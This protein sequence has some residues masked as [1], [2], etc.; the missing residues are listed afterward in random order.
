VSFLQVFG[1][2]LVITGLIDVIAFT[3]YNDYLYI[4]PDYYNNFNTSLFD[5]AVV[6]EYAVVL[7]ILG[8]LLIVNSIF[9]YFGAAKES[10]QITNTVCIEHFPISSTKNNRLMFVCVFF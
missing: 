1:L 5:G 3:Y 9:G 4:A 7:M 8:L 10:F 2:I 6:I